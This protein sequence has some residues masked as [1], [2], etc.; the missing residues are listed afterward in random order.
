MSSTQ[1]KVLSIF[2]PAKI[3]LYLHVTG[4]LDNGYHTLDSLV[5]FAD[6]GDKVDICAPEALGQ[7]FKFEVTGPFAKSFSAK[8]LDSSPSSANL[9]VRVM[10]ALSQAAQKTPNL[11]AKLTKNLPLGSG[12]GGGSSDAAAMIWGLLQW[13]DLSLS[14]RYLPG[15]MARLGADIPVCLPCKSARIR[16]IGDVLDPVP[17]IPE[18]PIVLVYPGK[19][20][21]T[22]DVFMR[23]SGKLKEPQPLPGRFENLDALVAFLKTTNNDLMDAAC[24]G[25]PEIGNVLQAL[26]VQAGCKLSR[27]TGSGSSCFGLFEHAHEAKNAVTVLREE[28]PDWWV[29]AGYLG[30][31][32][33]Y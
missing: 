20:C 31:P 25:V 3:N 14:T 23:F 4:R 13:W 12:L 1:T 32:E 8:E 16:G 27:L 15:L 22:A 10:W 17:E 30:S 18:V 33:R 24:E 29:Q 26:D 5:A 2:A 21:S 19:P 28:N 9:V 7:D 6:I 11:H